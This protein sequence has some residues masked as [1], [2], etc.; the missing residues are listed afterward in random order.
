[1][2]LLPVGAGHAGG[3]LR[4]G[5]ERHEIGRSLAAIGRRGE[6]RGLALGGCRRDVLAHRIVGR[7]GSAAACGDEQPRRQNHVSH[8]TLPDRTQNG[9]SSSRSSGKPPP[10]APPPAFAP[11]PRWP[12]P[13][14]L[15]PRLEDWPA[16][17]SPPPQ[18]SPPPR[19]APPPAPGR[20]VEHGQHRIEA[21]EN[22]LGRIAV[23]ARLVL[24]LAGLQ[25][26]LDIDLAA[27]AQIFLRD[28]RQAFVEDLD[29]VP[30][31]LFLALA[32]GAILPALRRGDAQLD[33]LAAV[34]EAARFGIPAEIADENHLVNTARHGNSA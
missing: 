6:R 11:P 30:L 5:I 8:S 2:V 22:D 31:G 17:S 26:A 24:P 7:L 29:R 9:T 32:A 21:L 34:L 19:D 1:M 27:L 3:D 15:P 12:P 4:I 10:I 18:S 28:V 16:N 23:G 14:K 13:L 33:H 20:A 25:R